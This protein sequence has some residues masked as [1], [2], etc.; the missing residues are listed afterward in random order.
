MVTPNSDQ[1]SKNL[2]LLIRYGPIMSKVSITNSVGRF[3]KEASLNACIAA[4][5]VTMSE[6]P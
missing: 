3:M 2:P 4:A 5:T 1:A 6:F